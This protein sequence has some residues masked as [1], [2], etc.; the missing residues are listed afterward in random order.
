MKSIITIV[1][2]TL[3]L[4]GTS[5]NNPQKFVDDLPVLS[6]EDE[7]LLKSLPVKTLPENYA[8]RS[9][10]PVVDNSQSIYMRPAFNQDHYS[11]GQASLIGYNFTYEMARERNVS[12]NNTNNQY[13]TH[14]TW[15][16]MNGGNGYYGVSY[17]HSAQILKFCGTPSV[18][19]YGGMA[20]GGYDRWMS[21]Y[22]NYLYAMGNRITSISQIPV[23]TEEELQTLKYWLYDHHEDSEHGG[24]ASFYAQYLTVNQTLPAGTPEGGKYVI[25]SFG[26]SPNH[27]MTIV[28]YNDE[29]RWDYN[30]DGQYTNHIDINNDGVVNMKDWE[31]GG[32]KMVQSYGGV[33]NWGNQGYAYMMYKTVADKLGQGGIWNHCVHV[34]DVKEAYEPQLTAKIT[35]KHDRRVAIKVIVGVSNNINAASPEFIF[36]SPIVDFQGGDNYMQGGETEA[37]KTIVYGLDLSPLLTDIQL[38]QQVKFFMQVVENDPWYLGNGEIVSFSIIDYSNG[39]NEVVSPQ[40]NVTIIDNDTTTVSLLHSLNFDRIEIDTDILPEAIENEPYSFQLEATGG[41]V[42]YFWDFDK[43]YEETTGSENFSEIDAQQLYPS[44][45]SSG[46]VTH[47]LAF[48]FPFYDSVYSSVTLHVDGYLMFDEQLYPY[49]YFNDDNVLFKSSRNISP[50]MTQLQ[51]IYTSYGCGLW[52]EGDANAATFRWK[53]MITD[54]Y[55][56]VLNYS[57]TLFPDGKVKFNY[58]EMIGFEEIEWIGGVSDND[59]TNYTYTSLSD[60][61]NIPENYQINLI[62]YDYPKEMSITEEGL[63]Y[64][65]PTQSYNGSAITF[66]ATDNSFIS[67]SKELFFTSNEIEIQVEDYI[68]SGDDDVVEYGETATLSFEI[69]NNGEVDL[70]NVELTISSESEYVTVIDEQEIVG[71]IEAGESVYL[72]NCVSFNVHNNVPNGRVLNIDVNIVDDHT[73]WEI[74]FSYP[75][76]AP[77]IEIY[78]VYIHDDNGLLDP[79]ETTDIALVFLND[80]GAGIDELMATLSSQSPLVT[81]NTANGELYD[82]APDNTD[83]IFFNISV[84]ETAMSGEEVSFHV[85]MEGTL[86]YESSEDFILKI[87]LNEENFESGD[88]SLINWGYK[89]DAPW[90]IDNYLSYEGQYSARSGFIIDQQSSTLL[91]DITV[92]AGGNLSFYK[93]VSCEANN[94]DNLTFS[95]NGIEQDTWSGDGFWNYH[96]YYLAPGFYR[97]E[98]KYQ[99]NESVSENMD[100]A[101]IDLISFPALVE[102]PPTLLFDQ[103]NILVHIPFDQTETEVLT[104][105]N[106]G[107][108]NIYYSTYLSS[109]V[110]ISFDHERNIQGSYLNCNRRTVNSG[111]SYQLMLTIYNA[112]MDNEWIEEIQI[113]FPAGVIL[114]STSNFSGGAG[115]LVFEGELGDGVTAVWHGE[116]I[117]GWGV[118]Q[119]GHTASATLEIMVE[120]DFTDPFE[121][122][123]IIRGD[124]YGEE[125]HEIHGNLSFRNLGE[126]IEWISLDQEENVLEGGQTDQINLNINTWGLDV[127]TY[128]CNLLVIDNFYNEYIIPID[129]EVEQYV[130][131]S[132]FEIEDDKEFSGAFPNPFNKEIVFSLN[133]KAENDCSL[134][135]FDFHSRKVR[136]LF[137]AKLEKGKHTIVWDGMNE[138]GI[139]VPAGIYICSFSRDKERVIKRIIKQ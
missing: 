7:L 21:G 139:E 103:S 56:S 112:S 69:F 67:D 125:P 134:E 31:I 117:N 36:D 135:I 92:M 68:I 4:I 123:Y 39:T 79:G 75:A 24:L 95:V 124:V 98:W 111:E 12:A 41:T 49:P 43:T 23:G 113:D 60:Q 78:E 110:I 37:D 18:A 122:T 63:L 102:S 15:N 70:T 116:D 3:F 65:T 115:D 105:E 2:S 97:L 120:E 27:A 83:T 82:L 76:F 72:Q 25:T 81:I 32:F 80:G 90:Q 136:T 35:L 6:P 22:E 58:G 61:M 10:P 34:L 91:A 131:L 85:A 8:T 62:K 99:K 33:P 38:G 108:E 118:L 48:D 1:L 104:V 130:D 132:E 16:F 47:Q 106:E 114:E 84:V 45:N 138:N 128:T 30:N 137:S 29:I 52:Y 55:S 71:N 126:R 129:L 14:F 11:C 133:I 40:N 87:G 96:E 107:E 20:A 53:T 28:G 57:V 64:G 9:L 44:N 94:A 93:K 109:N 13:P 17:L 88:F 119:G 100:G 66:K 54:D 19:V 127:G 101:W 86:E 51:Q 42:P 73:T 74:P 89:G 121:I 59:F 50:F 26:G 77:E 5:Q 46:I